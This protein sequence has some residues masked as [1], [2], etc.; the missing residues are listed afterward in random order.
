MIKIAE[1]RKMP[2]KT[3]PFCGG[4]PIVQYWEE[5]KGELVTR[6]ARMNCSCGVNGPERYGRNAPME[7]L[8]A[9]NSRN[10]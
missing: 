5:T 1:V 8:E 6:T 10:I 2:C 4:T 3:C 7:A 9:W